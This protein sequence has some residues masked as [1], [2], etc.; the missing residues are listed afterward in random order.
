[1]LQRFKI[2]MSKTKNISAD[3]TWEFCHKWLFRT[4]DL[5]PS[6]P[7]SSSYTFDK[8]QK[9]DMSFIR[10]RIAIYRTEDT[11]LRIPS[12]VIRSEKGDGKPIAWAFMGLDGT[13]MSLHVEEEYR[14]R[15]LAK[16]IACRVM[17]GHVGDYG[18]DGWGAADV[19]V[20]NEK[21]QGVCRSVGGRVW[22]TLSWGI[23]DLSGL[24]EEEGGVE[25]DI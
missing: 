24:D 18:D 2:P 8:A 14:R 10:S 19:V 20:S 7:P 13:L 12:V 22:W 11:L 4:S 16:V 23:L 9:E 5:P 17:G 3:K 15:G 1:M 21:S 25:G 6:P